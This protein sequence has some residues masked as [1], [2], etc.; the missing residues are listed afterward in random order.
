MK[1]NVTFVITRLT[2]GGAERVISVI[3]NYFSNQNLNVK[4]IAL[5]D[6]T[7]DYHLSESIQHVHLKRTRKGRFLAI[8]ERVFKLRKEIKNSDVVISFLWF[9]NIYTIIA[10]LFLNVKVIISDRSD[11]ISEL[12]NIPKIGRFLR[13]FFYKFADKIVFQ[14]E[15]AKSYYSSAIQRKS[16]IIPNPITPGLPERHK[17]KRK[18]ELVAVCRLAPQ[19]NLKM[20]IDSFALLHEK[21]PEYNLIIYGEGELEKEIKDYIIK[22]NLENNVFLPGFKKDVHE[23]I[24]DSTMYLSSSNYEGISN[25]M[26]EALAMGLPS[27]VTDC[28]VG[29]ARMFI[30]NNI[31][32]ILVP[33][34]DTKTF[35]HSMKKII[36]NPKFAR[37][38]SE[39][40]TKIYDELNANKICEI[41]YGLI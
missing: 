31:N 38:L 39:N 41:W 8:L 3:A 34:G 9:I 19:K 33:V 27:V 29:G 15:E 30:K 12:E 22:L 7:V 10:S 40:A 26:L 13:D 32:G 25:S 20:M 4:V 6:H 36:E 16:I 35:Y 1:K 2:S 5:R 11:P 37:K 21:Y 28:P 17:G 18:K 24:V 23:R 14:T